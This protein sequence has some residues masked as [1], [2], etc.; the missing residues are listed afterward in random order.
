MLGCLACP[1]S[2]GAAV[3]YVNVNS[4]S[5]SSPYTNW[6]TAA[7]TIQEAVDVALAGDEIVVTNGLYQTG[8]GVAYPSGELYPADASR[9]ALTKPLLLRS[10]NGPEV[11]VIH[12]Y[13]VPGATNGP[14]PG[15]LRCVYLTNGATLAGFTLTNG[16]SGPFG[17]GGVLCASGGIVSNCVLTG[18]SAVG[19]GGGGAAGGTLNNCILVGN[20]AG[21]VGGGAG[22]STLNNCRIIGNSAQNHG[23]GTHACVLNNCLVTGNSAGG[24]GGGAEGAS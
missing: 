21:D 1:V 15:A 3:R 23:G 7:V 4:A 16:S 12:G 20:S 6:A 17:G 14:G 18:N 24:F 19:L 5:P 9:V 13:R 10:V 22:S 11:T 8:K 2:T